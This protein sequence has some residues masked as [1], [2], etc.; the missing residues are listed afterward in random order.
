MASAETIERLRQFLR[1]LSPAARAMLTGELE[2]VL[3][4]GDDGESG[5]ELILRQLRLIARE[6]RDGTPRTDHAARLFFRPFEPFLADVASDQKS[7]G[8][9]ARNS[10]Q[11]LWNWIGRDLLPDDTRAVTED[12]SAALAAG[13]KA[14][15]EASVRNF[16][17]RVLVTVDETFEAA[18]GDDSVRRYLA[19]KIG[20]PRAIEDAAMLRCVLRGRDALT[21]LGEDLP[22]HIGKLDSGALRAC[23]AMVERV[24]AQDR[25][26]LLYALLTVM[27]RLAAPWQLIRFGIDAANSNSAARVAET[28]YAISVHIVLAE[29]QRLVS[30]LRRDLRN[31]GGVAVSALVKTIHD[32]MRGLRSELA[33]P[34]DSSWG[35]A[36]TA[37]RSQIAE[38]LQ[39][40]L[41][42]VPGR[43]RRLLR[44]RPAGDIRPNSALDASE[45]SDT[46]VLIALADAC[47]LF[48]GELA[49]NE[50]THR[51]NLEL[52]QYL[53]AA[54][55][56]LLDGLRHVTPEERRFRQSQFEAGRRF[57]AVLFGPAYAEALSRAAELAGPPVPRAAQA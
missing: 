37:Q 31:G 33:I 42:A 14:A 12:V 26:L 47:R 8:P 13:D 5:A 52:R 27:N 18:A 40:E 54:T 30:E 35:R 17:E 20:T 53:D 28:E 55:Q 19:A 16:Q 43:V 57:C 10:I 48:A 7:P 3:L 36:L 22:L 1:E 51:A 24:V 9:V 29:L 4:R 56:V 38:L 46:E 11:L 32:C 50:V 25:E 41:D 15:A 6:R 34:V 45:V 21:K 39:A 44:P 2:R 23:K 49:I